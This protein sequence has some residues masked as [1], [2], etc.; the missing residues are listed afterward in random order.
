[1]GLA[2]AKKIVNMHDGN[3]WAESQ[4]DKGIP[5]A[6]IVVEFPFVRVDTG[7]FVDDADM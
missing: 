3:I 5:G 4:K 1:V 2:I 6:T 7:D